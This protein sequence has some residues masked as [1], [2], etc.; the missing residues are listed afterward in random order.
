[1]ID[2]VDDVLDE[3]KDGRVPMWMMF[4]TRLRMVDCVP[5]WMIFTYVDEVSLAV[6][7]DVPVVSIFD[8]Q[9]EEQQ[10]VGCHTTDEVVPCLESVGATERENRLRLLCTMLVR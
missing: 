2:C 6:Q 8:L 4:R 3:V 1:M 10:A 7:H 5:M 9:Q